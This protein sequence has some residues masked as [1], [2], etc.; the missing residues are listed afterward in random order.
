MIRFMCEHC[1][2]AVRVPELAAGKKGRCPHCSGIARVPALSQGERSSESQLAPGGAA[3]NDVRALNPA[4]GLVPPPPQ[5]VVRG[6]DEL[7]LCSAENRSLEETDVLPAIVEP[8]PAAGGWSR[9]RRK[10]RKT[11]DSA[12]AADARRTQLNRRRLRMLAWIVAITVAAGAVGVVLCATG[13][14]PIV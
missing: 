7:V 12:P 2:H 10:R 13:V 11:I 8:P 1:G 6:S 5:V 9:R 14:I 3:T 4:R